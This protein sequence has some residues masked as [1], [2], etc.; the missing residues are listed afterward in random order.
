MRPGKYQVAGSEAEC[1]P[2][3]G[4]LV[5]R[6]LRGITHPEGIDEAESVELV[7]TTVQVLEANDAERRFTADDI[8]YLHKLW[9]ESIYPW[10]GE[11]RSV[12]M[13]K[14]GFPFASAYLIP[15]L[16]GELED[17]PLAKFT[18][19]RFESAEERAEALAVTHAE[20]ILIHPFRE[21]N[22]RCARLFALAMSAQAGFTELDFSPMEDDEAGY[23]RA[24]HQAQ[25]GD[26]APMQRVFSEILKRSVAA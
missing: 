2:G 12:N 20:I 19:F 9:L 15:Q 4:N 23:I 18:P 21:G 17:G 11:Y 26:Y 24:I 1:E 22:G 6:N 3:S 10:A 5:L 7:R 14:D 13:S 8:R 16:M 25:R